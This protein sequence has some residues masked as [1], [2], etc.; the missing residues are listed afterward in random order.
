MDSLQSAVQLMKPHFW[1][2][3]LDLKDA[4]FSVAIRTDHRKYLRFEHDG[5]LYDFVCGITCSIKRK[6]SGHKPV[7]S[8]NKTTEN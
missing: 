8:Q 3:V 7:T 4:Y 2:A 1:M 5:Q 6:F